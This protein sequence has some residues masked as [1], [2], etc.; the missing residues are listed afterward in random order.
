MNDVEVQASEVTRVT[1]SVLVD[2]DVASSR[3]KDALDR[4]IDV[5]ERVMPD[6]SML[7]L[8]M[9]LVVL[10]LTASGSDFGASEDVLAAQQEAADAASAAPGYVPF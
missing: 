8:A 5:L 9:V 4:T 6:L 2:G 10:Y 7:G 3:Q 1:A